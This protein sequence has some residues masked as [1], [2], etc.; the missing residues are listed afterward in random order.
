MEKSK[1]TTQC[2]LIKLTY[3]CVIC[4]SETSPRSPKSTP[5]RFEIENFLCSFRGARSQPVIAVRNAHGDTRSIFGRSC[6]RLTKI[7][8]NSA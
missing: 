4:F 6:L 8:E 1:Q 7:W 2:S 3:K 5:H